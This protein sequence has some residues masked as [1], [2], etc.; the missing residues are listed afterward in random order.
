MDSDNDSGFF[1][2][3]V[4]P[5]GYLGL[6]ASYRLIRAFRRLARPSSPLIAKA[7]TLYALSLNHTTS[8]ILALS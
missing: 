4:S 5:F 8:S 6:N 2:H 1:T 3:R 7:S